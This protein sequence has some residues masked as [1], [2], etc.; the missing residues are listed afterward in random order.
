MRSTESQPRIRMFRTIQQADGTPKE[1]PIPQFLERSF[2]EVAKG[3]I[4]KV[5]MT[6]THRAPFLQAIE[7]L[8]PPLTVEDFF[9]QRDAEEP[10]PPIVKVELSGNTYEMCYEHRVDWESFSLKKTDEKKL[11]DAIMLFAGKPYGDGAENEGQISWTSPVPGAEKKGKVTV[12]RYDVHY[13]VPEAERK[14]YE[15]LDEL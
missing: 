12:K 14:L 7:K 10:A 6:L 11:S 15:M 3:H 8:D 5:K 9:R 13:N 1:V 2:Y 4:S